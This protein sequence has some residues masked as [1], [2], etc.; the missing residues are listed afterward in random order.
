MSSEREK[1]RVRV[2]YAAHRDERRAVARAWRLADPAR[3][4]EYRRRNYVRNREK[5]LAANRA[6][7]LAN[8]AK[9][10]ASDSAWAASH[11]VAG[12]LAR[13]KWG[14]RNRQTTRTYCSAWRSRKTCRTH[15]DHRAET[16]K[17]LIGSAILISRRTGHAHHVDHII[18][19]AEGGWHHHD[20][21]QVLPGK[22]NSS[23]HSDPFWEKEGYKSWKDVPAELW[24]EKLAPEY[25]AR[26][27]KEK[28]KS[29]KFAL[30][31]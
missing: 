6:W 4:A 30:A 7:R 10:R 22:L 19:L 14:K 11:P 18:P 15:V 29:E 1:A 23:K 13:S 26:I 5:I 17:E 27:L 20:N 12:A 8:P 31:A 9:K 2:Y 16:E 24:P 28:A 21:L 25:L 3:F